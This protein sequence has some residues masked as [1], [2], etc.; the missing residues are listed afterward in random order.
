MKDKPG[1]G[2]NETKTNLPK[3]AFREAEPRRFF[4]ARYLLVGIG[5]FGALGV[6]IFPV[7]SLRVAG[8]IL[9]GDVSQLREL[10]TKP[11]TSLRPSSERHLALESTASCRAAEKAFKNGT[12][13]PSLL[14]EYLSCKLFQRRYSEVFPLVTDELNKL[15]KA[16]KVPTT[17]YRLLAYAALAYGYQHDHLRLRRLNQSYC[18]RK[19]AVMACFGYLAASAMEFDA[20]ASE[21]FWDSLG[22]TRR[23]GLA[24]GY[25]QAMLAMVELRKNR[26]QQAAKRL[27]EAVSRGGS[28]DPFLLRLAGDLFSELGYRSGSGL[29]FDK[30]RKAY[31]QLD[32]IDGLTELY[33]F[34]LTL[35]QESSEVFTAKANDFKN[36]E[37]IF[38]HPRHLK[39]FA[40][41][42][43]A[44]GHPELARRLMTNR[45]AG[46]YE[47]QGIA[48]ESREMLNEW[49]L[50]SLL[51]ERNTP[52]AFTQVEG[53]LGKDPKNPVLRHLK[54]SMI[55]K[56]A[57]T[58]SQALRAALEFS[59]ALKAKMQWESLF[60]LGVAYVRAGRFKKIQEIYQKLD[61]WKNQTPI[62]KVWKNMLIAE[63]YLAKKK[64]ERAQGVVQEIL[65]RHQHQ[66][67]A[68]EIQKRIA[69]AQKDRVE[70]RSLAAKAHY[71]RKR[72][73][74]YYK[75]YRDPLGPLAL[76]S[77]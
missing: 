10:V 43:I 55:L 16:R 76:V 72:S 44:R 65:K 68:I 9:R 14:D 6:L 74:K 75:V 37:G 69:F 60:G 33:E 42:A 67:Y 41:E 39:Y 17:A 71:V 4:R 50:R 7:E 54:G 56:S 25:V 19:S 49:R 73:L 30:A 13:D 28:R 20:L 46:Y 35:G 15:I 21:G 18:P 63:E 57:R 23:S 27:G 2:P 5:L 3:L 66:P 29:A 38:E 59:I 11:K 64:P 34:Y 52:Q 12:G 51:A 24:N 58:K 48:L 45:A 47:H 32:R 40:M 36:F 26:F 70:F 61:Q 53:L 1:E 31:A 77:F 22:D 62:I 8:I